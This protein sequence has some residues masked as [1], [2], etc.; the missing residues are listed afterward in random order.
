MAKFKISFGKWAEN[1]FGKDFFIKYWDDSN[2][3][4]PYEIGY[5]SDHKIKIKCQEKDYHG[6]YEI[7]GSHF[8]EGNRCP[9]CTSKKV[10]PK[11]SFAQWGIDNICSDFLDKYWDWE[12]NTINPWEISKRSNKNVFIKCQEKEYHGSYSVSCTRFY[13]GSRCG[14]CHTGGIKLKSHPMDSIA[15]I[16]T[17]FYGENALD[18]YWDYEKNTNINPWELSQK[19]GIKIYVFDEYGKSY[20]ITCVGLYL[21]IERQKNKKTPKVKYSIAQYLIDTYGDDALKRYW[22]YTRNEE[23]PWKVAFSSSK[24][25]YFYCQKVK[26]HGSYDIMCSKF[27]DGIR[28]GYCHSK[29]THPLDSFAQ[30]HINNTDSNFLDLYW[31]YKKNNINPWAIMPK[32]NKIKIWIKCQRDE[33]HGSYKISPLNFTY[34][35]RC[36]LCKES[37]GERKIRRILKAKNIEFI[38]QK[39]FDGLY[40]C[41][42]GLLSYDFYLPKM[43]LLIEFQGIQHYEYTEGLQGSIENFVQ[44]Q[45]HDKRKRIY[46]KSKK[47][48]LL[49]IPYWEEENIEYILKKNKIIN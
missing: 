25:V 46:A 27:V 31:D 34:D 35:R 43:N 47:I 15:Y 3:Y 24:K 38:S 1:N 2:I 30:Y 36:P 37:N 44:Q 5:R 10:H 33:A 29:R 6:T 12:R 19:S 42:N 32:S 49:E 13:D 41:K 23:D 45:E 17:D 11:D 8:V 40:G 7:T 18:L 48:E 21:K 22:D 9:Y 39:T 4:N 20:K 14:Y 26:Y 28:C 16:L